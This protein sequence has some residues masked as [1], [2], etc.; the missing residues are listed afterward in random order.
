[1]QASG[2]VGWLRSCAMTRTWEADELAELRHVL[3]ARLQANLAS[4]G[5]WQL[6]TA[7]D[8]LLAAGRRTYHGLR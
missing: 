8:Q 5:A 1:M 3:L 4:H 6:P 2:V 7:A